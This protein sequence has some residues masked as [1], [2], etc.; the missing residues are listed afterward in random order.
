MDVTCEKCRKKVQDT[1]GN[2][3]VGGWVQKNPE[4]TP[5]RRGWV[6]PD[7]AKTIDKEKDA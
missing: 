4:M 2:I 1:L 5:T 6:C 7:C 3:L